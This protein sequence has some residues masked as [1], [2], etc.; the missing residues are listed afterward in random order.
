MALSVVMLIIPHCMSA[1]FVVALAPAANRSMGARG[2]GRHLRRVVLSF[3]VRGVVGSGELEV[4]GAVSGEMEARLSEGRLEL[5]SGSA[6]MRFEEL[7]AGKWCR[8]ELGC[9]LVELGVNGGYGDHGLI[10]VVEARS[11]CGLGRGG[12]VDDDDDCEWGRVG[13]DWADI[14]EVG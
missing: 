4:G 10:L 3:E 9:G 5:G 7:G 14:E 6:M 11:W 13:S 8:M 2:R 12:E 1:T